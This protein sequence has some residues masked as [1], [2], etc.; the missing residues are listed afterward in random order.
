MGAN[1]AR[2]HAAQSA[3]SPLSDESLKA[4]APALKTVEMH[5]QSIKLQ[6]EPALKFG[7]RCSIVSASII[8]SRLLRSRR[9][10]QVV[11]F[12]WSLTSPRDSCCKRKWAAWEISMCRRLYLV[13]L[14]LFSYVQCT[15]VPVT[16]HPCFFFF[17]F[18]G[19]KS[20]IILISELYFSSWTSRWS[21][22][23]WL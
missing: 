6:T 4:R 13:L 8:I 7:R 20:H 12:V 1:T 23:A 14:W 22:L 19:L 3:L 17:V 18:F 11:L 2:W 10:W 5:F 21:S 16:V 9:G 15:A